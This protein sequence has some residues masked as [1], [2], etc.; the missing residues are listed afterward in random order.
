MTAVRLEVSQLSALACDGMF[1]VR[2][3]CHYFNLISKII[4]LQ[5]SQLLFHRNKTK[6]KP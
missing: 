2:R 3:Q 5:K 1:H 4:P 6:T